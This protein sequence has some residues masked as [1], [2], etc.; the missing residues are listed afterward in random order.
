MTDVYAVMREEVN[1]S[2]GKLE[3]EGHYYVYNNSLYH[4]AEDALRVCEALNVTWRR[5]A[6]PIV[7]Y[8]AH[9]EDRVPTRQLTVRQ[10]ALLQRNHDNRT[11]DNTD[12][13]KY[14]DKLRYPGPFTVHA[15]YLDDKK[16]IGSPVEIPTT[17]KLEV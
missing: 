4:L 12:F 10:K 6:N 1:D 14:W 5:V 13:T 11:E 8:M 9:D 15:Y 3:F 17:R 16:S 2:Y 7:Y